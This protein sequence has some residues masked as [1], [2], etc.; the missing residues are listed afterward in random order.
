LKENI[1]EREKEW[2]EIFEGQTY[3]YME[4]V[5]KSIKGNAYS[6]LK[7]CYISEYDVAVIALAQVLLEQELDEFLRNHNLVP[8]GS[9]EKCINLAWENHLIS[10]DIKDSLHDSRMCR[11]TMLH[12]GNWKDSRFLDIIAKESLRAVASF[13]K[14]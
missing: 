3:V 12:P 13:L 7:S 2:N 5:D 10:E 8:I 14:L 9:F 4:S 1:S 6:E 11:N